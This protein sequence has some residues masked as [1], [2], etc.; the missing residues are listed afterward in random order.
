MTEAI[1][2]DA[3][4]PPIPGHPYSRLEWIE[5][6]PPNTGKVSKSEMPEQK[7]KPR[8]QLDAVAF[9]KASSAWT[10]RVHGLSWAQ[11]AQHSGYSD[12]SSAH[13]AVKRAFGELPVIEKEDLRDLWRERIELAWKQAVLDMKDRVPGATTASVRIATCAVQLDGLAAPVKVDVEVTQML[14]RI[15]LE[16]VAN[17]L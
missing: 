5:P 16:L 2:P 9:Q 15:A 8:T 3:V 17:D 11:V 1:E 14:E 10:A 12:A 13:H 7:K 6:P 4:L